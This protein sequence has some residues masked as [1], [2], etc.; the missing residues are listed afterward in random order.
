MR[1]I[2]IN[3][4]KGYESFDGYTIDEKGNVYSYYEKGLNRKYVDEIDWSKEPV[5][6][7]TSIKS[8]GYKHLG[9]HRKNGQPKYAMIH[10]LLALAFIENPLNLPVVNH[11]NGNKLDNG[12]ENLEWVDHKGNTT[13]AIENGIFDEK[14]K[15]QEFP[16]NQ[17]TMKGEF[18]KKHASITQATKAIGFKPSSKSAIS[19][20]CRGKQK[21]SG[22]YMWRFAD[23]AKGSTTSR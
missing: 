16:V 20:V 8:S 15:N 18:I 19:R 23:D 17:F 4:L 14:T 12:L 22:G 6:L 10:R 1:T 13:H 11:K 7:S 21:S 3:T 9:L 5:K 2:K